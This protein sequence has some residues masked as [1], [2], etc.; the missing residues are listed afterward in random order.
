MAFEVGHPGL[1]AALTARRAGDLVRLPCNRSG[2]GSA[3]RRAGLGETTAAT[4]IPGFGRVSDLH[5][6]T[7]RRI[8]TLPRDGV[9]HVG[10]R[11]NRVVRARDAIIVVLPRET[12][13][14]GIHVLC[15]LPI[16]CSARQEHRARRNQESMSSGWA[17]IAENGGHV[18]LPLMG[19]VSCRTV[20]RFSLTL[21]RLE[22]LTLRYISSYA[23]LCA[24]RLFVVVVCKQRCPEVALPEVPPIW[25]ITLGDAFVPV[26]TAFDEIRYRGTPVEFDLAFL[27]GDHDSHPVPLAAGLAAS[28]SGRDR[29]D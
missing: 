9:R 13:G 4:F 6:M 26:L 20:R 19:Q 27:G 12:V 7:D 25:R 16:P 23:D 2:D 14:K 21:V 1:N 3:R 28:V 10:P 22:R 15:K 17:A 5:V 24:R 18:D 11:F 8:R 29:V